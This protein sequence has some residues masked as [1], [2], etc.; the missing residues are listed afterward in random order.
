MVSCLACD[1]LL[2]I[3]ETFDEVG[4]TGAD[5]VSFESLEGS[6][7]VGCVVGFSEVQ[8]DGMDGGASDAAKFLY[9]FGFPDGC[10]GAS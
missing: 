6:F 9:Q 4:Q 8:E 10:G 3:P 7:S 5:T 2:F 1:Y